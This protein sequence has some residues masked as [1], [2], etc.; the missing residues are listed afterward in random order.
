MKVF[1]LPMQ[2]QRQTQQ[3]VAIAE[4][5][6]YSFMYG[7]E[8]PPEALPHNEY[9][10]SSI[11]AHSSVLYPSVA[12]E[13]VTPLSSQHMTPSMP[14]AVVVGRESEIARLQHSFANALRGERQVV[15]VAGE[16]G[17][18]KTTLVDAFLAQIRNLADVRI[19]SGQCV[20]QYGP[21]EA[22]LPLLEATA[23]LCRGPGGER[24]IAALQRY[25]PSWFAQ[26]P[27]LWGQQEFQRVQQRFQD[28]S[29][30]RML[31]EMAETAEG[32]AT[33][34]IVVL[35]LEDLHW[36]DVATLD[37]VTYMARR[38]APARLLILGTYRPA[39]VPD[40]TSPLHGIVQEL[41]AR[42]LCEV[43]RL[44]PLAEE[45]IAEYLAVRLHAD[46]E[47]R[48]LAPREVIPLL[49]DRTGGNPLFL[50]NMVDDLIRQGVFNE[51]TGH[52]AFRADAVTALSASLPDT[53]RQL[54][55]RQ[56]EG[57][58]EAEQRLLEVASVAGVEFAAAEVAT[59]LMAEED[60]VEETCE[61]LGRSG[62]WLQA[63][64]VK[65][66][67]DGTI[68]GRYSFLHAVRHEVVY[69]QLVEVR[70]VQL[71]RRIAAWKETAY[72]ERIG[73]IAAEL[74]VHW[75]RGR[76][77]GKAVYYH[78]LAGEAAARAGAPQEALNHLRRGLELL[79]L[80]PEN[81][82]RMRH[83]VRLQLSLT[84]PLYAIGGRTALQEMEHA[85]LRAHELCRHLG[86]PPQL[87]SILF[88]LC[89]VYELR[90]EV[91][92]GYALAQQLL[93]LAQ[94]MQQ[95]GLLLRA[96][97]A[98]GNVLYF[99]GD[100]STSRYHLEQALTIYNPDKHS[101]RVSN[102]AQDLG[103]VC[104]S[105][106]CWVLWCLGYPEQ[107]RQSSSKALALADELSHLLSEGFA[108]D[109]AI[110][111]ALECG[112]PATAEHRVERMIALS[113]EQGFSYSLA[114][115]KIMRGWLL[116]LQGQEAEG[117]A[118]LRQEIDAMR[119]GGLEL[120]LL[121]FMSL[122]AKAYS[123]TKQVAEGLSVLSEA[124]EIAEQRGEQFYAA[125]LYRLKGELLLQQ[126]GQQAVSNGQRQE[127]AK[128]QDV[129]MVQDSRETVQ[130]SAPPAVSRPSTTETQHSALSTQHLPRPQSSTPSA[131][132]LAPNLFRR[133]GEY[134][135]LSFAGLTCRVRD[136]RG[137]QYLAQLLQH[138]NEE[139]HV[140][141]L[142]TQDVTPIDVLEHG[143]AGL[144]GV[145]DSSDAQN[146]AGF[147]DVGEL[148]DPQA[149]VA[150]RQ[151]IA[152]LQAELEDAAHGNVQGRVAQLQDELTFLTQELARATGLG[153]RARKGASPMERARITVTKGIKTTLRKITAH[154]PVLGRHLTLTIKTGTYC[155]YSPDTR[156][157]IDWQS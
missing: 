17:I 119:K 155:S 26:L 9:L 4:P 138:P 2:P 103:V 37:W 24:R 108:L 87:A 98:L 75:E 114:W 46:A 113:Q 68:S 106:A 134:W 81:S 61:R 94:Q 107:A 83:E 42:G 31:R 139:I 19:T 34:R 80:L 52:L 110:G 45:A 116:T 126:G 49:H 125:E 104:F 97:M 43:L 28:T 137:L 23:R 147:T 29:R 102:V 8:P 56:F 3:P 82:E 15:F 30:E 67:P 92:K 123:I 142:V 32:L 5:T 112:D 140:S 58:S 38:R 79:T 151:R 84:A 141:R 131:Q 88:G 18:G 44:A 152:E 76:E 93:T 144:R 13:Q 55:E 10:G 132:D 91:H 99:L 27:S 1:A 120:G 69:A 148:L 127:A 154:H 109:G 16:A 128:Q 39:A 41:E 135:T 22:Y 12:S 90:G 118:Q 153:G 111:V 21:G 96:H 51:E 65:E 25:A 53:V 40:N 122:L 70:R 7:H 124:L 78:R 133:E 33:T 156:L 95:S 74:A 66:W 121:Y 50:V 136:T 64:G 130:G 47:T 35:V 100:F 149:R 145:E 20:E 48:R 129:L 62:Q 63:A 36:S 86:E 59:G 85:Y 146:T 157:P 143:M 71:H 57:L 54:I 89:M 14:P 115:G 77:Y 11:P 101:P 6:A 60:R 150:Y 105:R 117:I 73:E 72:G